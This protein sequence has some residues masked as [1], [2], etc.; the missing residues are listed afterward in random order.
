VCEREKG[1]ASERLRVR[2]QGERETHTQEPGGSHAPRS[3]PNHPHAL[4]RNAPT[5]TRD[6]ERRQHHS[7][8]PIP[9]VPVDAAADLRMGPTQ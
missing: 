6:A 9:S 2:G 7:H 5:R 8:H 3:S 1:R 4:R